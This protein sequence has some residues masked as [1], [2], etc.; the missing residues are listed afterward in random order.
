MNSKD[1]A[2]VFTKAIKL[3][4]LEASALLIGRVVFFGRADV[5]HVPH[6]FVRTGRGGNQEDQRLL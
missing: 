6:A 3:E 2:Y 1:A 4:A 5:E